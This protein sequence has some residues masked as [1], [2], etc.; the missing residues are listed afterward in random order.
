VGGGGYHAVYKAWPGRHQK[1]R[2]LLPGETLRRT[3]LVRIVA[4]GRAFCLT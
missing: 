1:V 4:A 2:I 3:R